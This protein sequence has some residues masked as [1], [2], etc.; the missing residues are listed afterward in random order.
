MAY[1]GK[2]LLESVVLFEL[3]KGRTYKSIATGFLIGFKQQSPGHYHTFI[4]TNKHVLK[5]LE[6]VFISFDAVKGRRKRIK[7][8]L[9]SRTKR[10][11][12]THRYKDVDIALLPIS[13]KVLEALGCSNKW[14]GEDSFLYAKQYSQLGFTLGDGVFFAGFPLGLAGKLKNSPIVRSGTLARC[15]KDLLRE[16]KCY[17]IDGQNFPGNSGGPVFTKPEI[18]SLEGAP[19]QKNY[20]I[21]VIQGYLSHTSHYIDPANGSIGAVSVENSGLALYVPMDYAK[22]I[23]NSWVRAGK[24]IIV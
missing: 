15:D 1:F 18:G 2:Q 24:P 6:N 7:V 12:F 11:W 22:Q 14:I 13:M 23:Y 5:D 10:K 16:T 19:I 4:I 21:G 3:K 9:I 8:S 20:L 17:L